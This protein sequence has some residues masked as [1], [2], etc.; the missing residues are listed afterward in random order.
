MDDNHTVYFGNTCTEFIQKFRTHSDPSK[1]CSL[2]LM[3]KWSSCQSDCNPLLQIQGFKSKI[4]Y[5]VVENRKAKGAHT[6][7]KVTLTFMKSAMNGAKEPS[8]TE[9]T[10]RMPHWKKTMDVEISNP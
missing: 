3:Q 10:L 1:S 9:D 2:N 7:D 4:C 8:S 6:T 5:K